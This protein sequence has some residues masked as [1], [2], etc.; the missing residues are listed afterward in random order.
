MTQ[1][2]ALAWIA[3]VFEEP[4]ENVQPGTPRDAIAMWDSLGVLALM[5]ALDEQLDIS[6][7]SDEVTAIDS[8]GGILNVL[9]R[10]DK[11]VA[12]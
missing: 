5:A 7:D 9:H 3:E 8:V 11:I 2:E 12:P 10:H 6:I 1:N 4:V